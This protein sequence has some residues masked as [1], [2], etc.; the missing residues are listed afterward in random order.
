MARIRGSE[1][2][3]K[4][5]LVKNQKQAAQEK[6]ECDDNPPNDHE[7]TIAKYRFFVK[8]WKIKRERKKP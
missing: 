1:L 3:I 8:T 4:D 7:S 5:L 6:S 2:S